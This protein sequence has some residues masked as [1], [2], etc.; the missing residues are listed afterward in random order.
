[1][2][3][4]VRTEQFPVR[5]RWTGEAQFTAEISATSYMLTSVKLGLAVKWAVKNKADLSRAY[6]SGANIARAVLSGANLSGADL[7]G[8]NLSRADISG[9]NLSRAGHSGA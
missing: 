3:S 9:A 6:L 8:A 2:A 7:S 1:M 4:T 5:N